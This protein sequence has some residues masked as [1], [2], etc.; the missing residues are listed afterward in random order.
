MKDEG[1]IL[2]AQNTSKATTDYTC[3]LVYLEMI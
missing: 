2:A 3:V 1:Q